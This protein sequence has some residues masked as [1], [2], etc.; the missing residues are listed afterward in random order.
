ML[1]VT[2]PAQIVAA[3]DTVLA[4]LGARA[5][6]W[7]REQRRRRDRRAGRILAARRV[8]PAV[9]GELLRCGR[10]DEGVPRAVASWAGPQRDR[11][12][13]QRSARESV[14]GAVLGLEACGRGPRRVACVTSCMTGGSVPRWSSPARSPRRSG[15][16]VARRP[17]G[18]SVTC[19][20]EALARYARFI[21][22]VRR[23]IDQ[24]EKSG[25]DPDRVAQVVERALVAPRP[26]CS[27]PGWCRRPR[28][29]R[30]GPVPP[31]QL[32]RRRATRLP[33]PDVSPID[34]H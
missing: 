31:G 33:R 18:S 5:A 12:F 1:D 30:A 16:R 2:D 22:V 19:R 13:G 32:A 6:R 34:G 26:A 4:R 15:T 29:G 28:T 20:P 10:D 17:T 8:A 23:G 14:A 21:D 24:Q 3:R 9:R 27:L 7:S 11:G 25:V